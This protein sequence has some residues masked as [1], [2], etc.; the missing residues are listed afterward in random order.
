MS[1]TIDSTLSTT[2]FVDPDPEDEY[3]YISSEGLK[4]L[5]EKNIDMNGTKDIIWTTDYTH[6]LPI[7]IKKNGP[8]IKKNLFL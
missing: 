8:G 2:R 4:R 1:K 7:R 3:F 5:K 6:E